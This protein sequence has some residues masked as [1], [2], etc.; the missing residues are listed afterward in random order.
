MKLFRTGK[1]FYLSILFLCMNLLLALPSFGQQH[2]EDGGKEKLQQRI[3]ELEKENAEL[4]ARLGKKEEKSPI[5][6]QEAEK[7]AP[8]AEFLKLGEKK[9]YLR[10]ERYRIIEQIETFIP[11]LYEPV[12]PF[13]AFTIPP[14][15]WRA[16]VSSETFNNHGDFGSDK[17]YSLFFNKV[18]AKN[19]IIN[20]NIFYGFE[21]PHF[22]DLVLNLNVPYKRTNIS[23]TGHPFWIDPMVMTMQG[24]S[25]GIGDISLTLKEKWLDQGNWYVNLASF[26][27]I[28]FPTGKHHEQF[29]DCQTLFVNHVPMGVCASTGGPKV[30]AFGSDNAGNERFLPNSAQPGTGAWGVR[31]GLAGTR[32]FERSA[33]HAGVIS[34]LFAKN[35]DGITP[36][37]EVMYGLSYVFPPLRS[38]LLSVDLSFFGRWKGDEKFP[39]QITHPLRDP[40]TGGP[41]MNP[42]GSIKMFTTGRPNFKHDAVLFFSPSLIV[43]PN[44]QTRLFISPAVRV[45]EPDKGPSPKFRINFGITHTFDMRGLFPLF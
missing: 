20:A 41:I 23:G 36:G 29:N 35:S 27:G 14:G 1:T 26:L 5:N 13:H 40:A 28:I 39:G 43:V 19:T 22:P 11:P 30:D 21:L 32:Q 31:V 3:Q 12:R 2:Q 9:D 7:E 8:E 42:D 44:P 17:F 15:T 45:V 33:L 4:E 34:N 16:S 25:E 10:A 6:I 24:D 18:K 37:H 38:D